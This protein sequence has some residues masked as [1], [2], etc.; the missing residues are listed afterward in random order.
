VSVRPQHGVAGR[1]PSRTTPRTPARR[2]PSPWQGRAAIA[3]VLALTI[4]V[5]RSVGGFD[6]VMWDDLKNVAENPYLR[7]PLPAA[8]AYFWTHFYYASYVPLT[9]TVWVALWQLSQEAG[10]FHLATLAFHLANVALVYALL[11]KLPFGAIAAGAGALLFAVHPVQVESVAWITALKDV[12]GT[13]FSLL[14]LLLYVRH[15]RIA[16]D[17]ARRSEAI[18]VYALA[19]AA[20]VCALLSKASMVAVPLVAG[21]LA[22]ALGRPLRRI[23]PSIALW[24]GVTLP[25]VFVARLAERDILVT[26]FVPAPIWVRPLVTADAYGFYLLKLIAP[27]RLA[28]DYGRRPELVLGTPFAFGAAAALVALAALLVA[29]RRRHPWLVTAAAIFAVGVLPVSGLVPFLYQNISTV[30]DRY[31]YLAML[32]PAIALAYAIDASRAAWVSIASAVALVV[33]AA[34][35]YQ[36]AGHWRNTTTLFNQALRVNPKSW[37]SNINVG[38]GL[39]EHGRLEEAVTHYRAF[40]AN[41]PASERHIAHYDL[42]VTLGKL[43]RRDEAIAHLRAALE[44][45]PDYADAHNELGH[46][47]FLEGHRDSAIVEMREVVR[48]QPTNARAQRI[49]GQVLQASGRTAE[50][51]VH[52]RE[53]ARLEQRDSTASAPFGVLG[54]APADSTRAAPRA[55]PDR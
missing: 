49:L 25:F 23:L 33:L 36:Q 16:D 44:I 43:G 11:R 24:I 21:I 48:L 55:G 42:A 1:G 46:M 47:L 18:R 20:F 31:L 27:L 52:L 39:E 41:A 50:A 38:S 40:L 8:A 13:F 54:S 2:E 29:I 26:K 17:A 12:L 4:L 19:T 37:I 28:I 22:L 45:S 51:E 32:G 14:A 9:R 10:L 3:I 34:L 5:F 35:S 6:F 15:A 7:L 30:A 53:A